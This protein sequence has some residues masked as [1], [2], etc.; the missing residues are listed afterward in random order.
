MYVLRRSEWF[1]LAYFCYVA[2]TGTIFGIYRPWIMLAAIAAAVWLLARRK[3]VVRDLAPLAYTLAAYREMNWF[4]PKFYDHHLE[5]AWIVWD[6]W[7]LDD[8]HLRSAIEVAGMLVPS[9]LE[10]CYAL[11]Y[12]V[13]AVS[14]ALLF[15]NRRRDHID[16]FWLAYLVGTLGADPLLQSRRHDTSQAALV[17]ARRRY[18]RQA[19]ERCSG[20]TPNPRS[21]A[22]LRIP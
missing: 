6:R 13:G 7:L 4:A 22:R 16:R 21:R 8:L 5:H 9:Y 20:Y 14:V 11:V 2:I 10:V 18:L 12:A 15:A 3:S 19:M 1:V 17:Q